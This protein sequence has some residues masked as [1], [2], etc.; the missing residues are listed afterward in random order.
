MLCSIAAGIVGVFLLYA[1]WKIAHIHGGRKEHLAAV[2]V[3]MLGT[4]SVLL[5]LEWVSAG[6]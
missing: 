1:A 3:A 2:L 5:A 6:L 4:V